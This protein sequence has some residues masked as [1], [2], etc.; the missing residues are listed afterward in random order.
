MK[1]TIIS[2]IIV[3][4]FNCSPAIKQQKSVPN[5][6]WLAKIEQTKIMTNQF[7]TGEMPIEIWHALWFEFPKS[8]ITITEWM[9]TYSVARKFKINPL[10]AT[11]MWQKEQSLLEGDKTNKK[12]AMGFYRENENYLGFKKQT[13]HGLKL[14][15][16]HFDESVKKKLSAARLQ[17]DDGVF[18]G[19]VAGLNNAEY[20][21]YKYNPVTRGNY[22]FKIIRIKYQKLIIKILNQRS[23]YEM[24]KAY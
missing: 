23:I 24:S 16:Y 10:L 8:K 13:Y 1:K 12:L 9:N 7:F 4:I 20:A 18:V 5:Y 2:L 15:K 6:G 11:I 22:Y 19:S 17:R 3:V 21:H 14:L